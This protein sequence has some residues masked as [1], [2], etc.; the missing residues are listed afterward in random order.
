MPTEPLDAARSA[1]QPERLDWDARRA[2][3]VILNHR[4]IPS[5]ATDA[6]TVRGFIDDVDTGKLEEVSCPVAIGSIG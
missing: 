5:S 1:R 2:I 4:W 3:S 6:V